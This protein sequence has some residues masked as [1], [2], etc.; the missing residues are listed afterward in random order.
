M[1]V[2]TQSE[3]QAVDELFSRIKAALDL[4]KEVYWNHPNYPI[5]MSGDEL[6]IASKHND[7]YVRLSSKST[8]LKESD[9]TIVNG[10][11]AKHA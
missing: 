6:V 8:Y 5:Q 4:G 10:K 9:V 7:H 3:E 2:V 1:T 11:G